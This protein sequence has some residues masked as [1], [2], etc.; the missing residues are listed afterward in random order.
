MDVVHDRAVVEI[1][2][3][4]TRG[5]RFCQAGIVYRPVRERSADTVVREVLRSLACTGYDEVVAHVAVVGGPLAASR[6][7]CAA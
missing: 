7:S 2:R 3:G 4:C 5:C 6:R 1:T